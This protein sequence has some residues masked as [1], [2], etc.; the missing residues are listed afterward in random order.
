MK[1]CIC[2]VEINGYGNNPEGA[3]WKDE[4]G[5]IVEPEFESDCRCCDMCNQM[6]VIPGRLYKLKHRHDKEGK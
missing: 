2:G 6:Y 4:K 5:N 3:M 1:C